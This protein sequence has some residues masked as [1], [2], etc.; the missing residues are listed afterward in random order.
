MEDGHPARLG[1]AAPT[2]VSSAAK[3]TK[4]AKFLMTG[5]SLLVQYC[6]PLH[7]LVQGISNSADASLIE[8][9]EAGDSD[10]Y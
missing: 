4:G 1:R 5:A 7:G 8:V 3:K 6:N 2:K 10:S 9:A